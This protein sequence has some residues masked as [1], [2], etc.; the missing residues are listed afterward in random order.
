MILLD[1]GVWLA[2]AWGRHIH[3]P[4]AAEWLDGQEDDLGL[5]RVTQMSLLRL[6]SNP[7]VMHEDVVS[8]GD[9]WRVIDQIRADQR[10]LWAEEPAQLEA[11][12]RAL[13][14]R[15]EISNKLW[16]DDY[17]AAFSQAAGATL[18]TLD[19]KLRHRYP[20]IHVDTLT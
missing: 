6:L 12:W 1:A 7:A 9:A 2:A 10:V 4:V 3:H 16:T 17:L 8:R 18:A 15:D 14:A 5:C 20:S 11:V 13:S 19:R